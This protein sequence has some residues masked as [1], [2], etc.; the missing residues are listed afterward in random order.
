MV[1]GSDDCR[2]HP[3]SPLHYVVSRLRNNTDLISHL[4]IVAGVEVDEL[5]VDQSLLV[6]SAAFCNGLKVHTTTDPP[7]AYE[8]EIIDLMVGWGWVCCRG[9]LLCGWVSL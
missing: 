9:G 6:Y 5:N 7:V 3:Y 8:W 1:K 4:K 2:L